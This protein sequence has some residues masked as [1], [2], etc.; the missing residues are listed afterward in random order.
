MKGLRETLAS[1]TLLVRLSLP[2][3]TPKHLRAQGLA[4]P[5]GEARSEPLPD[6][7]AKAQGE[8]LAAHRAGGLAKLS[9]RDLRIAAAG[10]FLPPSPPGRDA[11][12]GPALVAELAKRKIRRGLLALIDQ[13]RRSF[14]LEDPDIA[15]LGQAL[16]AD[17][18][19]WQFREAEMWQR[20]CDRLRFF[21]PRLAPALIAAE[22]MN[23]PAPIA[24]ALDAVGLAAGGGLAEVAFAAAAADVRR[25]RPPD[26]SRQQRL[27]AWAGGPRSPF[28]YPRLFAF[29]AHALLEPWSAGKGSAG[30]TPA[31]RAAIIAALLEHGGGD[32]RTLGRARWGETGLHQSSAHRTILGW[33]TRAS[34]HQ[35][36]DVVDRL[37]NTHGG[38]EHWRYRRPFWT[39]YL[40]A[41]FI[42]EAWVVFGTTGARL[43]RQAAATADDESLA[44][45]G[46]TSHAYRQHNAALLLRIGSLTILDWSHNGRYH[47]WTRKTEAKAPRLYEFNYTELPVGEISGAHMGAETF[48]WQRTVAEIIH[49]HTSRRTSETEWRPRS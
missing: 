16:E 14:A 46:K 24:E 20:R 15:R 5:G 13:Y 9:R 37:L 4:L 30:P 22:V 19:H 11:A 36:F 26:P 41:G 44:T 33:L 32:P 23:S 1:E 21:D 18:K 12:A 10:F 48:S 25:L 27:I 47:V 2:A 42:E 34:V 38:D 6:R 35:F 43:A 39:S 45:F 3:L 29:Y 8:V 28:A 7:I 49:R 40:D 31:H 17:S